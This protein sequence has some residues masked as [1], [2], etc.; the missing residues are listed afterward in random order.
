MV[1]ISDHD[2]VAVVVLIADH[3]SVALVVLIADHISRPTSGV[4]PNDDTPK[5]TIPKPEVS[6]VPAISVLIASQTNT[7]DQTSVAIIYPFFLLL[8]SLL[9]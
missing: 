5:A 4:P 7:G 3:D 1:L 2:S 6:K 9:F 8:A